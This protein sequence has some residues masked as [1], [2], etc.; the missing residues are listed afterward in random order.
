M[1]DGGG[2]LSSADL[3][4]K[5]VVL[6]FWASWCIPC[7]EEAPRLQRAWEMYRSQ[8]ITI[9]G[10][11]I[12]DSRSDAK[13]FVKEFG[14]TYPVVRDENSEVANRLG[15]YG[16][17]E[18]FFVDQTWRLLT[19]AVGESPQDEQRNTVVLGAISAEELNTNIDI[20]LRR[21]GTD[22]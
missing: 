7:R 12:K 15:V 21:A 13:K 16:L 8:G 19:T 10:I 3:K 5:S 2:T 1:L 17:P 20:L 6:N 22:G 4:G 9:V 18:T 14:I 11:N